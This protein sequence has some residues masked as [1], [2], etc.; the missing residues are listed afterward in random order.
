MKVNIL[1]SAIGLMLSACT[2][3]PSHAF[4][5]ETSQWNEPKFTFD[6]GGGFGLFSP[7]G[8]K[9]SDA[10]SS[11]ADNSF[12]QVSYKKN[13]FARLHSFKYTNQFSIPIVEDGFTTNFDVKVHIRNVG[14]AIGYQLDIKNFQPYAFVGGGA[15]FLDI[16]QS[17]YHAPH[18]TITY[19][20]KTD[21]HS[22]VSWGL[23][24]NFKE[25]ESL[26]IF[27][28]ATGLYMHNL[29]ARLRNNFNGVVLSVGIR[30]P[31]SSE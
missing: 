13:L 12:L 26:N 7:T 18:N 2:L 14:L 1:F 30:T 27:V 5:Q 17:S 8:S 24:V 11:F 25:S 15:A 29:E 16:P 3:F 20:Q 4:A 23:G 31:L 22:F 21:K 19:R 28:E 9:T 10:S 6:F